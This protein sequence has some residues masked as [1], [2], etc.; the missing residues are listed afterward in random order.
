MAVLVPLEP[1]QQVELIKMEAVVVAMK[2]KGRNRDA[3]GVL[4]RGEF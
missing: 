1:V 2:Q 4:L 3:L